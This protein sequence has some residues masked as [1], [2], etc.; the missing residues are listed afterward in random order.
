M[1]LFSNDGILGFQVNGNLNPWLT[2]KDNNF[3]PRRLYRWMKQKTKINTTAA[4][5]TA[6]PMAIKKLK[7]SFLVWSKKRETG[8]QYSRISQTP[9]RPTA[10][11]NQEQ[12]FRLWTVHPT[13]ID[14]I[15]V[16]T[17]YRRANSLWQ[18]SLSQEFSVS[19]IVVRKLITW[20]D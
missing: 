7:C 16:S 17:A 6:Q 12:E 1:Q 4:D 13:Q 20:K 18:I 9:S 14:I 5:A 19:F 11:D 15:S 10:R 3:L 8:K 2:F